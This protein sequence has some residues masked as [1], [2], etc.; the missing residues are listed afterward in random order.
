MRLLFNVHRE[1]PE[2]KHLIRLLE[3]SIQ[4]AF[5]YRASSYV[6]KCLLLHQIT[7][8]PYISLTTYVY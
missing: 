8:L 4:H 5:A 3:L 6:I 7:D 1:L 2:V